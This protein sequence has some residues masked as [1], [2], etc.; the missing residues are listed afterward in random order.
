MGQKH[1]NWRNYF[2]CWDLLFKIDFKL[3]ILATLYTAAEN[4]D[5]SP[6]VDYV[7]E[8]QGTEPASSWGA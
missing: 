8:K 2:T 7:K 5:C 1:W 3:Q 4:G 6:E